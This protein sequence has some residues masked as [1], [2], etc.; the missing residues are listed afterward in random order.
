MSETNRL[1]AVP[2]CRRPAWTACL[3]ALAAFW[4]ALSSPAR[5]G[6]FPERDD[7]LLPVDA[8][9][10]VG[11]AYWD[12]QQLIIE[13]EAAADCYFYASAFDVRLAG[14]ATPLTATRLPDG[15]IYPDAD[16]GPVQVWRGQQSI[17]FS[18]DTAPDSVIVGYQGCADGKV[19]YA[20][21]QRELPVAHL[22]A[23]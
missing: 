23:R 4:L 17:H 22:E 19:C 12:G 21:Q 8:A 7:G 3:L 5:A 9:L 16:R 11:P 13:L 18:P 15:D 2:V 1:A 20:P 14:S 10:R 6:L